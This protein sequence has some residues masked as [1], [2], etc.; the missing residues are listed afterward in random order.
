MHALEAVRRGALPVLRRTGHDRAPARLLRA[1]HGHVHVIPELLGRAHATPDG[2]SLEDL[3]RGPPAHLLLHRRT[4]SSS[5]CARRSR[6]RMGPR[7]L[8]AGAQDP[9]GR[10]ARW[11]RSCAA[12]WAS[13]SRS[14]RC[15]PHPG[16]PLRG[17]PRSERDPHAHRLHADGRSRG[18]RA[19]DLRL[20]SRQRLLLR[21]RSARAARVTAARADTS[22]NGSPPSSRSRTIS[23]M[24]GAC[25]KPCPEKPVAYRKRP[26]P[27]PPLRSARCCLGVLR[28]T[29]P[30]PGDAHVEQPRH[31][32]CHY[33]RR[34]ARA[35]SSVWC[36]GARLFGYDSRTGRRAPR[37]GSRSRSRSRS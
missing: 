32:P 5:S 27:R 37:G 17:A 35:S 24:A 20:V 29:R 1:A 13:S 11:P 6:R 30:A 18:G 31:A 14:C 4:R 8:N 36:R 12:A 26:G 23:P 7:V 2:G 15:G 3:L 19:A 33:R 22:T 34:R 25:R 16:S 10:S 9:S 28:V 21:R